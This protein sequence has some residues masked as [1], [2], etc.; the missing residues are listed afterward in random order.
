MRMI[1]ILAACQFSKN[2]NGDS[3]EIWFDF[4]W[5]ERERERER[6]RMRSLL[7][8]LLCVSI[9]PNV[10]SSGVAG[11]IMEVDVD[12]VLDMGEEVFETIESQR[13]RDTMDRKDLEDQC[14]SMREAIRQA[15]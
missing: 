10:S 11:G 2:K 15:G 6:E 7:V 1:K 8:T 13:K 5:R 4:F 3:F 9:L 14:V 12:E